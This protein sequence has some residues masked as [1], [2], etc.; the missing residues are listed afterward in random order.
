[1]RKVVAVLLV[2]LLSVSASAFA[3]DVLVN[4][5]QNPE[6][7]QTASRN[8]SQDWLQTGVTR[9]ALQSARTLVPAPL[10]QLSR[11]RNWAGRHP[12]LLGV[13]AGAGVGVIAAAVKCD[14]YCAGCGERDQCRAGYW[15]LGPFL[16]G[17]VGF[18]VSLH[19]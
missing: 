5:D 14:G 13:L 4:S 12:V 6:I 3:Q 16:G 9:G 15:T 10:Q 18:I 17:V 19:R 11:Q 2:S 7:G 8:L 1:M